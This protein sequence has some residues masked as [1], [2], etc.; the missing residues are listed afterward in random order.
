MGCNQHHANR[1]GRIVKR[2]EP[3]TAELAGGAV[4]LKLHPDFPTAVAA[5]TRIGQTFMPDPA[6]AALYERLYTGVYRKM[7]ARL[8]PLNRGIAEALGE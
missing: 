8:E 5:M 1:I 4:G 6:R 2:R 7:Y 3:E